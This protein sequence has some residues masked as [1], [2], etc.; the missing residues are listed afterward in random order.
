M[1]QKTIFIIISLL[2]L[3]IIVFFI[4]RSLILTGKASGSN[5]PLKE[6]SYLFAS[7]IQAK[8]DTQEKIRVTVFLLDSQG[9]GVSRI[10]VTL[11]LPSPLQQEIIQA[12]TDDLGQ[13]VF[14]VFSSSPGKFNLSASTP[15]FKFDQKINLIFY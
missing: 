6:N 15:G 9:L 10:P 13:A 7:P 2:I 14:N 4:G 11:D 8:A 3:F 1:K 12:T 5:L